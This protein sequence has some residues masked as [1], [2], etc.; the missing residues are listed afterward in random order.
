M[1][2]DYP[3]TLSRPQAAKMCGISVSTFDV[4][5]RKGAVP[6][7][8][9]LTRRW[10]RSGIVRAVDGVAI[11]VEQG[12][13]FERWERENARQPDAYERQKAELRRTAI[14]AASVAKEWLPHSRPLGK[15]ERETLAAIYAGGGREMEPEEVGNGPSTLARLVERKFITQSASGFHLKLTKAGIAA[16]LATQGAMKPPRASRK[17]TL[18]GRVA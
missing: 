12:D 7:P 15:R 14:I 17:I 16:H 11:D 18:P 9:P 5:V 4:W 3:I 6:G 8:I 13:A 10:S 1:T 2:E